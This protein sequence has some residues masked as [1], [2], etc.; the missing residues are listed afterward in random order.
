M[1]FPIGNPTS[2]TKK[3]KF[4][5]TPFS[6]R[7]DNRIANFFRLRNI[8]ND[9]NDFAKHIQ[10][11][12][13]AEHTTEV[14]T[15]TV[16]FTASEYKKT[17]TIPASDITKSGKVPVAIFACEVADKDLIIAGFNLNGDTATIDV[18]SPRN[19][20]TSLGVVTNV[21][22]TSGTAGALTVT[23]LTGVAK[24]NIN[25]TLEILYRKNWS[26]YSEKQ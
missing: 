18:M 26:N 25:V 9:L 20:M 22:Y 2:N 3:Y 5:V 17:I 16:S 15:K 24:T 4:P 13:N 12:A 8:E 21:A 10:T 6:N 19:F 23:K 1:A 7:N 14:I 11:Y